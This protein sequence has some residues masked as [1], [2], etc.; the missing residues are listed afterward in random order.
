MAAMTA[1]RFG[2]AGDVKLFIVF[3]QHFKVLGQA[4]A[5]HGALSA[6]E[7]ARMIRRDDDDGFVVGAVDGVNLL[8]DGERRIRFGQRL[9][10]DDFLQLGEIDGA[11]RGC[12]SRPSARRQLGAVALRTM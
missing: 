11:R 5:E 12:A 9:A 2:W 7:I 4:Q 1:E 6:D 3:K 10:D 8:E